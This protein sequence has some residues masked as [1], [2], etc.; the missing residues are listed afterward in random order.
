MLC[1]L[2]VFHTLPFI[3]G[4]HSGL[5][6][7]L[8]AAHFQLNSLLLLPTEASE[9]HSQS[10]ICSYFHAFVCSRIDYCNSLLIGLPK[11]RLSP[12]QIVLNAAARLIARLPRYSHIS[13]YIKEHLHWLP[14]S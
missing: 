2:T 10:C 14:I 7:D 6:L 13:Y 12:L 9:N 4:C 5:C 1:F 11:T 8:F 3:H